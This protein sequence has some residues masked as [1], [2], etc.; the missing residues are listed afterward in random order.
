[1]IPPRPQEAT[2]GD[3]FAQ[4]ATWHVSTTAAAI[5]DA[6]VMVLL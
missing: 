3:L 5:L 1:M 2:F 6:E 4:Q